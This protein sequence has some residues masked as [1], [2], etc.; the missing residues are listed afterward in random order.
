MMPTWTI[1][2]LAIPKHLHIWILYPSLHSHIRHLLV[3]G[4]GEPTTG[5][6]PTA[7]H[8]A[9]YLISQ[10]LCQHTLLT[11]KATTGDDLQLQSSHIIIGP[12]PPADILLNHNC[13]AFPMATLPAPEQLSTM[14]PKLTVAITFVI[15]R[16]LTPIDLQNFPIPDGNSTYA[17][18]KS[19]NDPIKTDTFNYSIDFLPNH[20]YNLFRV[21][22]SFN[23]IDP[24][25]VL[26][27]SPMPT[28]VLIFQGYTQHQAT[29]S[30]TACTSTIFPIPLPSAHTFP[31]IYNNDNKPIICDQQNGTI[32][33]IT[34]LCPT[35]FQ[36]SSL[37]PNEHLLCSQPLDL[38]KQS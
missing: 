37:C 13:S 34:T 27:Q 1:P 15:C 16:E 22:P 14:D 26:P 9:R 5:I 30:Y 23:T 7:S 4:F 8:V 28:K 11:E 20:E 6:S 33:P 32:E 36:E 3:N 31:I 21:T 17:T 2:G 18:L 10:T 12:L 19:Y 35:I 24:K 25:C 29:D 38:P